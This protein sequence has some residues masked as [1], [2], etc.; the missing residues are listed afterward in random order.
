[1]RT[2]VNPCESRL[3]EH[4]FE[5]YLNGLLIVISSQICYFQHQIS[6]RAVLPVAP[7]CSHL[8]LSDFSSNWWAQTDL[9]EKPALQHSTP[10]VFSRLTSSHDELSSATVSQQHGDINTTKSTD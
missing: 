9:S 6:Q 2:S 5:V 8:N 3:S 4:I 10:A 7:Q 1:M